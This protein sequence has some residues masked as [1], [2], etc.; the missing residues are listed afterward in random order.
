MTHKQFKTMLDGM[1]IPT[2]WYQFPE[3][4]AKAPPFICFFSTGRDDMIADDMNYSPIERMVVE[5]YTDAKDF[6][7]EDRL[8]AILTAGGFV[9]TKEEEYLDEE[10][11]HET[12]YEMDLILTEEEING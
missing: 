1:Q 12:I 10:H 3:A 4:T 2:A 7:L 5:L 8:E 6:D 9:Y 11:M